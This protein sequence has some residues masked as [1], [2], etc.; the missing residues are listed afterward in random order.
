MGEHWPLEVSSPSAASL[1]ALVVGNVCQTRLASFV[2][3]YDFTL[4]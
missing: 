1:H 3:E 2:R 4:V